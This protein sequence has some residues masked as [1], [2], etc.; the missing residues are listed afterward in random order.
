MTRSHGDCEV[1]VE[2]IDSSE[3]STWTSINLVATLLMTACA[4]ISLN[5]PYTG[6]YASAGD[7]WGIKVTLRRYE[8][9]VGVGN[10]SSLTT[11]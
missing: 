4:D 9:G 2:L 5:R 11:E 3:M 8:G 6:G 10:A 1:T 7:A